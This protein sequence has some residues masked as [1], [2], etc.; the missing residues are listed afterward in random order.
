[1]YKYNAA[2]PRDGVPVTSASLYCLIR[3][4]P[5]LLFNLDDKYQAG[6]S[7]KLINIK[8]PESTILYSFKKFL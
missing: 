5:N 2:V 6:V 8:P 1:M 7:S 4:I 3:F